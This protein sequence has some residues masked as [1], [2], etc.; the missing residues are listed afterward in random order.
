MRYSTSGKSVAQ[1]KRENEHTRHSPAT[2]AQGSARIW[3]V[4]N[5]CIERGL[6]TEG[7]LPG[8][9]Y[10]KRRAKGI[11][12]ALPGVQESMVSELEQVPGFAI[13]TLATMVHLNSIGLAKVNSAAR[14]QSSRAAP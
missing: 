9:L 1:M 12:D 2:L 10:V 7:E 5:D 8:G 11:A 13:T 3:Q 14:R 4:M 6:T